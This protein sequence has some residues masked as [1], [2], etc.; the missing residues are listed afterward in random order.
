MCKHLK[1]FFFALAGRLQS[2]ARFLAQNPH[3]AG[4]LSNVYSTVTDEMGHVLNRCFLKCT[5]AA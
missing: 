3:I 5:E 4:H 2:D 1:G